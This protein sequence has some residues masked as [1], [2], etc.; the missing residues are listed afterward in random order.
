MKLLLFPKIYS[1]IGMKITEYVANTTA[2][3]CL[4][5]SSTLKNYSI[6]NISMHL[7]SAYS[8]SLKRTHRKWNWYIHRKI[9]HIMLRPTKI[10]RSDSHWWWLKF[11]QI[12]WQQ[13]NQFNMPNISSRSISFSHLIF[14]ISY[15]IFSI[16]CSV[17][18][19]CFFVSKKYPFTYI[20]MIRY[21][22]LKAHTTYVC[23]K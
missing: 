6:F 22:V 5:R 8:Y 21:I 13:C 20:T 4:N 9:R 15:H 19:F 23:Q 16:S 10:S 17:R 11:K 1:L 7:N 14:S 3:N 12:M 18:L 2:R